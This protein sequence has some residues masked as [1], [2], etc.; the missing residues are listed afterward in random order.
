M[1][2]WVESILLKEI[3]NIEFKKEHTAFSTEI[4]NDV[5]SIT[6]FFEKNNI[7]KPWLEKNK[8]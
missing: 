2:A 5:E 8:K 3:H 1:T 6:K 4:L 7:P